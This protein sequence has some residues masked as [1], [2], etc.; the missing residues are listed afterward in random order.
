M[1]SELELFLKVMIMNHYIMS[2]TKQRNSARGDE[3][4]KANMVYLLR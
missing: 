1:T 3:N 2:F 4:K